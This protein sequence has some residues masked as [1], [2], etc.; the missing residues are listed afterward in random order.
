[1]VG[2]DRSSPYWEALISLICSI[3]RVV[4]IK[5]S[6]QVLMVY[7][8]DTEEKIWKFSEWVRSRLTGENDLDATAQ[9]IVRAAVWIG[10]GRM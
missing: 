10:N 2:V 1:M 6:D 9:E 5:E 7:N 4:K 3:N 8:L